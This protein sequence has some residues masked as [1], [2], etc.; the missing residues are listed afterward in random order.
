MDLETKEIVISHDVVFDEVSLHQLESL[1]SSQ[2]GGRTG[3]LGGEAA[4]LQRGIEIGS[5]VGG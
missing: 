4:P 1:R 5:D 3:T 2:S